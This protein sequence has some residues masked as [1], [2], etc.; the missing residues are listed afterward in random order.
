MHNGSIVQALDALSRIRPLT[1]A[2][3]LQLE[4]A[5]I[6]SGEAAHQRWWTKGE[7]RRLKRYLERGKKPA[8]IAPLLNRTERSIWRMIYRQK[9]RVRECSMVRVGAK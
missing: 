3:A 8:Q 6:R 5:I 2:E 4:R 9:W 1:D 7:I